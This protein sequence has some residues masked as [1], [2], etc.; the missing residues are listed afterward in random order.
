LRPRNLF[1]LFGLSCFEF[2]IQIDA[3]Y[4]KGWLMS[5]QYM[6]IPTVGMHKSATGTMENYPVKK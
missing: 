2:A 4:L 6:L 5:L 1:F 3:T